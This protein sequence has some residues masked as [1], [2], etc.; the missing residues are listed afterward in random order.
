MGE[1]V[2]P[3]GTAAPTESPPPLAVRWN[4][5]A[6]EPLASWRKAA[7]LHFV[8]GE[9]Y[10]ME[11]CEARSQKS[12]RHYFAAVA[13]IW[14]NL[15]ETA[16]DRFPNPEALRAYGLIRA[17]YC[18]T[19]TLVCSS[20]AEAVRVAAFM[21]RPGDIGTIVVV[22]DNTITRYTARSQS[23]RAMGTKKAFQESKDAVLS[24]LAAL[25]DV[26]PA[27]AMRAAA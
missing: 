14:K 23:Q 4:G 7:D 26:T 17:G 16:L 20:K 5:E 3:A 27:Q 10:A 6:F 15:P 24:V 1:I 12:H 2:Q 8:I 21:R 9:V 25:I 13:E 11:L 22:R 18:D 19:E